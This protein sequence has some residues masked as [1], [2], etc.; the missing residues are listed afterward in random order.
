[1]K[2]YILLFDDEALIFSL[3]S[4]ELKENYDTVLVASLLNSMFIID[5]KEEL[6]QNL[7]EQE[8]AD[9]KNRASRN[10][11]HEIINPLCLLKKCNGIDNIKSLR[12]MIKNLRD[13]N[14]PSISIDD[15]K[16]G[17][18]KATGVVITIK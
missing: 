4:N 14:S 11:G 6:P 12:K 7:S 13:L 10:M 2:I 3:P 18:V 17:D 5:V 1:M 8:I 9:K 15:M 16:L